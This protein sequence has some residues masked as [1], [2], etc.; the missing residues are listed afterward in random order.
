VA[1]HAHHATAWGRRALVGTL[2][3]LPVELTHWFGLL[4]RGPHPQ[5]GVGWMTWVALVSSTITIV[6]VGW[7][8]YV[9]AL[10]ALRHK[11]SNMD[12]LIAMGQ[13][14]RTGT[15]WWRWVG[16][17]SGVVEDAAGFVL[18]GGRGSLGDCQHWALDGGAGAGFG[19]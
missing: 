7:G 13:A 19:G 1:H 16:Y 10:R 5:H 4:T 2:L 8:F 9:S 14:S 3:W 11:T 12:T 6:Y 15:A 18:H 17:L